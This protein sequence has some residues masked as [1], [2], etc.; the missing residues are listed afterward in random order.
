MSFKIKFLSFFRGL[1]LKSA[2]IEFRAKVFAAMLLAKKSISKSDYELVMEILTEIYPKSKLKQELVIVIIKDY[3]YMVEKYKNY[4][5]DRILKEIDEWLK[6]QPRFTKKIN[7]EDLRR[8][9]SKK[10]ENDAL[11]QQ[12]VY[13]FLI[14]EVK[15]YEN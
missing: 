3:V 8:L 15:I 14:N 7:F 2:G 11:V 13:E 9:V 5:L 4:N 10:D 1:F 6:K 12:R